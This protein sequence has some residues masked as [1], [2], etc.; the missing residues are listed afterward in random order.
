MRVHFKQQAK[1]DLKE[2]ETL[3]VLFLNCAASF[4]FISIDRKK[5][6]FKQLVEKVA[7]AKINDEMKIYAE[8][9]FGRRSAE[10]CEIAHRIDLKANSKETIVRPQNRTK[11]ENGKPAPRPPPKPAPLKPAPPQAQPSYQKLDHDREFSEDI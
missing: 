8:R 4:N 11:A 2:D 5:H 1:R 7:N 9:K 10:R 6:V 3:L